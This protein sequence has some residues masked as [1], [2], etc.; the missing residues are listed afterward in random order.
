MHFFQFS[1]TLRIIFSSVLT[2][3]WAFSF[4]S[5]LFFIAILLTFSNL[6]LIQFVMALI[7]DLSLKTQRQILICWYLVCVFVKSNCT[8]F[9]IAF[10]Y[11]NWL[12]SFLRYRDKLRQRNKQTVVEHYLSV[13]H[14]NHE[15]MSWFFKDLNDSEVLIVLKLIELTRICSKRIIR[16]FQLSK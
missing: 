16:T 8:K 1:E 12:L 14:N 3:F 15:I 13:L 4:T 7:S 5:P 9:Q 2:L 11:R 10:P 6:L